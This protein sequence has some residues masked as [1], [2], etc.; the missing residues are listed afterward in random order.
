MG[1][2]GTLTLRLPQK[3]HD[4]FKIRVTENKTTMSIVVRDMIKEYCSKPQMKVDTKTE[5]VTINRKIDLGT[6]E[7]SGWLN[8]LK[9][10]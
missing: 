7:E 2:I 9:N 4:E 6:R 10:Y 5:T 3:L 8:N 1:E